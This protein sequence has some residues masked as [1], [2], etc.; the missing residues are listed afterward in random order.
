M[1]LISCKLATTTT[2]DLLK[3]FE[4]EL[5]IKNECLIA[6]QRQRRRQRQRRQHNDDGNNDDEN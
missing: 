1:H 2:N 5:Y 6:K 3:V 4:P